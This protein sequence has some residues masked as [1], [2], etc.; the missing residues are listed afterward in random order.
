MY[1]K[2]QKLFTKYMRV[3]KNYSYWGVHKNTDK[4]IEVDNGY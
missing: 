4:P 3:K 1:I 2:Y